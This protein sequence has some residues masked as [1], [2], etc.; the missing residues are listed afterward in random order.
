M[1]IYLKVCKFVT[2]EMYR[3]IYI[4]MY[5][6]LQVCKCVTNEMYRNIYLY[7]YTYL[8]TYTYIYIY[9]YIYTCAYTHIHINMY[10]Y[11]YVYK[12]VRARDGWDVL[13]HIFTYIYINVYAHIYTYIYIYTCLHIY[14]Y[15][16]IH[17]YI[18]TFIHMYIYLY[19]YKGVR[20]RDGWDV[21]QHGTDPPKTWRPPQRVWR[22]RGRR[23]LTC[24]VTMLHIHGPDYFSMALMLHER[25]REC[26]EF[27][28]AGGSHV[29]WR[30][31][32][33]MVL[34]ISIW[35]RCST[36][37]IEFATS[38]W[39]Q[40]AH[41]WPDDHVYMALII[42]TLHWCFTDQTHAAERDASSRVEGAHIKN[43]VDDCKAFIIST[44]ILMALYAYTNTS[45]LH[46][47]TR[48]NYESCIYIIA[49]YMTRLSL[50]VW[51][52]CF[53]NEM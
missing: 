10:I 17:I 46:S 26:D 14:I 47:R 32:I 48:W 7:T 45:A 35:H 27:A 2:D 40:V 34:T 4:Y 53:T 36:N 6:Y 21:S 19:I 29:I 16:Y 11:L 3:N 37:S 9:I 30:R 33:H 31:C 49:M 39:A 24:D 12:G 5:I 20:A 51:R 44:K 1:Y 13:Q 23:C 52:W 22:V 28:G 42:S 43:G 18:Y 50:F 25:R 8:H 15:T 41:M 38:S